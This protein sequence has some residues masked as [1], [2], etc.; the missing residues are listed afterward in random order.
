MADRRMDYGMIR[1]SSLSE[2]RGEELFSLF[3]NSQEGIHN[4]SVCPSND[5]MKLEQKCSIFLNEFSGFSYRI[6]E[7][8]EEEDEDSSSKLLA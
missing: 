2:V 1:F 8:D 6:E 4:F 7:E 3:G 5:N